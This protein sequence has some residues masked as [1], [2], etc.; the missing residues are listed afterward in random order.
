MAGVIRRIEAHEMGT[1]KVLPTMITIGLPAAAGGIF[2]SAF[3]M[4]DTL[5]ISWLGKDQI[6]GVSLV[7]P[8]MFTAFAIAQAVNVGISALVSRHLGAG[9][10][11]EAQKVMTHGLVLSAVVG[12]LLT[13]VLSV[14]LEPILRSLGA[15]GQIAVCA[16]QFCQIIFLGIALMHVGTAADGA[17]RAQGDTVTPMQVGI[18]TNI[19]N[20]LLNYTF[21]FLLHM[22]VRG[23]ATA[24]LITRSIMCVVLLSRLWHP[25]CQVRPGGSRGLALAE[26]LRVVGSI[27]WIG[28]PASV[29]MLA[30]SLSMVF[31][32]SLLV[33]MDPYAVG[34]LGIAGRLEMMACV[35]VFGLFSAVVPMVGYNL[36]A[37]SY[38]RIREVVWV[39]ACLSAVIMGISGL[40]LFLFPAPLFGIFTK[41]PA[42]LPLGV[43]YLRIMM[44]VYPLIGASIMMS[45]AFQGL[46]MS[47]VAMVMHLWRNII[48][49][50]PFAWWFGAV[51]GLKGVW[52]SFPASTLASAG[53]VFV[54]MWY[55]LR[56]L[57]KGRADEEVACAGPLCVE[58]AEA[59]HEEL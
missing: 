55:V 42:M 16:R 3:E 18:V 5:F 31:I 44:P 49:K 40:V 17:L 57:G 7:G 13:V 43:S 19:A 52:W 26:R 45:A 46:G 56:G 47:W 48:T 4:T 21:I 34:V 35:P 53:F 10:K 23:S 1:G 39:S 33:R 41:D 14:A 6:S 50:L 59:F 29:G 20:A 32:N 9:R 24:T 11:D 28:I 15:S 30:M 12:I 51:W 2:Q 25:R 27:Y 36:G 37:R 58:T 38:E 8:L 54:W 22:G